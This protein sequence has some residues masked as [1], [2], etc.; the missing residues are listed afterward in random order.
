MAT[1]RMLGDSVLSRDK[2]LVDSK[3]ALSEMPVTVPPGCARYLGHCARENLCGII[4][5]FTFLLQSSEQRRVPR[6][7]N[8]DARARVVAAALPIF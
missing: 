5:W 7:I 1:L 3:A 6:V 4:S 8:V 2:R